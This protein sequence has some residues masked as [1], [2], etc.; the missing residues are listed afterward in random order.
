[1]IIYLDSDYIE[2]TVAP[3]IFEHLNRT[4]DPVANYLDETNGFDKLISCLEIIKMNYYP[5]FLDKATYLYIQINK[6]HFFSNGNKRLAL[7][8]LAAFIFENGYKFKLYSKEKY[9]NKMEELF[10]DY[11]KYTDYTDFKS[12]EYAFYNL[13]IIVADSDDFIMGDFDVMKNKVKNLLAFSI[14]K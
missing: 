6:G 8:T 4:N 3:I 9:K 10:P 7:V 12:Y 13:S 5:S 2:N 14:T 11:L 1:M